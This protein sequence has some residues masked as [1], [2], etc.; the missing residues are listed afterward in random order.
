SCAAT[1]ALQE[2]ARMTA[3]RSPGE[4]RHMFPSVFSYF[5][6]PA[7][8]EQLGRWLTALRRSGGAAGTAEADAQRHVP[9]AEQAIARHTFD[10]AL[11]REGLDACE[12]L[13]ERQPNFHAREAR[14]QTN[15]CAEA[16][17]EVTVGRARDVEAE[18]IVEHRVVAIG[19]HFPIGD[20]V[21]FLD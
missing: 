16:E 17:G 19:R 2:N 8:Q 13:G 6:S 1:G 10:Q 20:L 9:D 3:S 14:A 12:K 18:R 4:I 7:T 15:V 21:A 5:Y 11:G